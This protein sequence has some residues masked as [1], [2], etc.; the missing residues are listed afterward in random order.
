MYGKGSADQVDRLTRCQA[1]LGEGLSAQR[2][3][4]NIGT[5]VLRT[6]RIVW[7]GKQE[8]SVRAQPCYQSYS[9]LNTWATDNCAFY[10]VYTL[11]RR[12]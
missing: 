8:R 4:G 11:A 12:V 6:A 2:V 5:E 10:F 9:I 1:I 3:G 7:S